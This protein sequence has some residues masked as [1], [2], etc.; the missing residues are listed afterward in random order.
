MISNILL[1]SIIASF[2]SFA[3]GK[4]LKA[5]RW[6]FS[7]LFLGY[8]CFQLYGL[9]GQWN[10]VE[11][12]K[13]LSLGT[14][15]FSL[16]FNV[17]KLGWIFAFFTTL[18][19]FMI[20]IFSI[21]KNMN[22][23]EERG[24]NFLWLLLAGSNIAIFFSMDWLT[25]FIAWEIMTWTSY[26][27]ITPGWK[28]S[29]KAANWYFIL[30]MIG[31]Y[32]MLVG[33]WWMFSNPAI[34]TL[35]IATSI[36][37]LAKL[38]ATAPTTVGII[39]AL[40]VM[41]FFAKS[42]VFPFHP[43]PAEAHAEAPDDFSPYLSG[44]MIK[45]GLYGILLF[46]VPVF[47]Q[48]MK[49]NPQLSMINGIPVYSYI[50]AW[51]GAITA[52]LG[53][54]LA[55]ISND[56]K[57]LAAY[58]TVSNIG[59]AVTSMFVLSALGI[60]G[61]LFHVIN[62]AVFK[63]SI[64]LALG[65]VKFRTHEREMHRLGGLATKMPITFLTFLLGI[66]AAAGIPPLNAYASKWIIFQALISG[67]FPFLSTAI[68]LASTF[69]FLYLFRA[70]HSIFLGQLP[71]KFENVKEVPFL[72]QIPM[73][74]GMLIMIGIGYAPGIIL[75]PIGLAVQSMGLT[76]MHV[77]NTMMYGKLSS[78]DT[79]AV[80]LTF[81]G[82]SLFALFFY[83]VGKKRHHVEPLDNYTAGQDP[84]EYGLTPELYH[85][86]F[87]FYEP[88]K[89]M[90][91]PMTQ[92]LNIKNFYRAIIRDINSFGLTLSEIFKLSGAGSSMIFV[93]GLIVIILVGWVL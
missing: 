39:I 16:N 11:T 78:I 33:I 79:V 62:H 24:I 59:Y 52:V 55:F 43:W 10:L 92:K 22:E 61:G 40:F 72:M 76:P 46:I 74:L 88:I 6:S 89:N 34:H 31:A 9:Y 67:H 44:V 45:Y 91:E 15:N 19:N 3:F 23:K 18:I 32:A 41:S 8:V 84:E 49:F 26:F 30:S 57:K 1:Y 64:F 25:F 63:S 14:I 37:L 12:H 66:I 87:K 17:T 2:I 42:A 68:F 69:A 7:T 65:A 73:I 51:I 85:F 58:S 29:F 90:F 60:T 53:A 70:L 5:L 21:V 48:I 35:N 56:M 77:E 86:A 28:N 54:Y 20:W 38:S 36:T 50:L 47:L 81:A 75:K 27:I 83:L 13:I 93:L 71:R 80:F 4:K 82:S